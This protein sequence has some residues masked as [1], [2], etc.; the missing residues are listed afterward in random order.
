MLEIK[1]KTVIFP[2][3]K[4]FESGFSFKIS[5]MEKLLKIFNSVVDTESPKTA[6]S[7]WIESDFN[8][9]EFENVMHSVI[10]MFGG[11]YRIWAKWGEKFNNNSYL[12]NEILKIAYKKARNLDFS[13][14]DE[15]KKITGIGPTYA[16]KFVRF[17]N[18][19]FPI[20][21]SRISETTS[22]QQNNHY[23]YQKYFQFCKEL[24][25]ISNLTLADVE[26]CIFCAIQIKTSNR[27]IWHKYRMVDI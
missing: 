22:Y 7:H 8:T 25:S 13:C 14:I 11:G 9:S 18:E 20:L 12:Y 3:S 27:E 10:V 6:V 2:C 19:N 26:S 5:S 21:D 4:I 24:S 23:D 15:V 16:T 1:D 17:F